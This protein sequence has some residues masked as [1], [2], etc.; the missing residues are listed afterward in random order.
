[1]EIPMQMDDDPNLLDSA[2]RLH[3]LATILAAGVLRLRFRVALPDRGGHAEAKNLPKSGQDGL[4]L[5]DETVLS[6]T[7]GVNGFRD[8]ERKC[9]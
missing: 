6:V 9:T 4:E 3:E 7:S 1:M 8:P 5:P 2:N